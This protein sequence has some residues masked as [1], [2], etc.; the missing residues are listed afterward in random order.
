MSAAVNTRRPPGKPDFQ[1]VR[2]LT[3]IPEAGS[4]RPRARRKRSL[5]YPWTAPLSGIQSA[6]TRGTGRVRVLA[7]VPSAHSS[8]SRWLAA[9]RD[10]FDRRGLLRLP[11]IIPQAEVTTMRQRLWQHLADTHAIHPDRPE[12]WPE[13]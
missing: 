4:W 13:H 11:A 7:H 10:E 9:Q 8:S 2:T 12:T 3:P 6:P 5:R 1:P